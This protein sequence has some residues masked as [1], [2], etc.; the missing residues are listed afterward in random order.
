L[1]NFFALAPFDTMEIV[2]SLRTRLGQFKA[3]PL[4]P[5]RRILLIRGHAKG[6]EESDDRF[7][8]YPAARSWVELANLRSLMA[9]RAEAI[10]PPG[11]EFGRIFF[12]MLDPGARLDWRVEDAPYFAR[13]T[14]AILPLRTNPATLLICG[15]ETASPGQGWLTIVS[16]RLPHAAINMGEYPWVWLVVDFRKKE[17]TE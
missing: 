9:R 3:D 15:T 17:T 6:S 7:G 11:V 13:W 8:G 16:P 2:G 12:E 14:R 1:A 5:G 4:E 10:L